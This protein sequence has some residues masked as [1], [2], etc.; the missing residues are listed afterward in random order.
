[1]ACGLD[2]KVDD[3]NSN[4]GSSGGQFHG[5]YDIWVAKDSAGKRFTTGGNFVARPQD[6]ERLK[7]GLPVTAYCCWNG[8]VAMDASL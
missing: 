4:G 3:D 1:M 7:Q 2:F 6:G 5:F 8:G